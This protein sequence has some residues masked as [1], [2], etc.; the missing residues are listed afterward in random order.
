VV[1]PN[2]MERD[3]FH[4]P[5]DFV[6][7]SDEVKVNRKQSGAMDERGTV[8]SRYFS[9]RFAAR[10]RQAC[11]RSSVAL[12]LKFRRDYDGSRKRTA[13]GEAANLY[14]RFTRRVGKRREEGGGMRDETVFSFQFSVKT[15]LLA[16][17]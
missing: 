5:E 2:N 3:S 16:E 9:R 6:S 12:C 14:H 15:K 10:P 1:D 13:F 4:K 8:R 11:R 7:G 17:N